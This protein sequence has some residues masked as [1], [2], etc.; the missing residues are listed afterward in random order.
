MLQD[1]LTTGSSG[2]ATPGQSPISS[3]LG[4]LHFAG[5][6]L[7]ATSWITGIPFLHQEG[8]KW[9]ESRTG[10]S[11]PP[12]KLSHTLAP[13]EMEHV[14]PPLLLTT[15]PAK[16]MFELPDRSV[17]QDH[18]EYFC[19]SVGKSVFPVVDDVLFAE[20][21]EVAYQ[22]PQSEA[23]SGHASIRACIFGFLAFVSAL[24]T[25][26][27][28][29]EEAQRTTL[30]S[31]VDPET[32]NVKAQLLLPLVLQEPASVEALQMITTAVCSSHSLL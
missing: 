14:P 4:T 22:Q 31:R 18:F 19:R 7:G 1:P 11:F 2:T 30:S 16:N 8:R 27:H 12:G 13:W 32:F 21:I 6:E 28:C 24:S 23:C 9:V 25:C 10:Q 15:P 20:T 5:H 26:D 29:P 3:T 17:V